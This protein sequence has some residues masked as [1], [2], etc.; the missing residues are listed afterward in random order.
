[1]ADID[2]IHRANSVA[3]F[4]FVA[5]ACMLAIAVLSLVP[6]AERPHTGL[7]GRAEH[8]VAYAGTGIFLAMGYLGSRQR[9]LAWTGLAIASGAFEILQGFVAGRSPNQYDVVASVAGLTLGF[10]CGAAAAS[11]LS[12]ECGAP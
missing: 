9:L 4:R 11:F 2:Q 1:M 10:V 12:R 8:F 7:P 6:G 5:W 3:I